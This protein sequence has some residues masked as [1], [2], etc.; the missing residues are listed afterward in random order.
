MINRANQ[1]WHPAPAPD[2]DW[3]G[4]A[5]RSRDFDD[6]YFSVDDGLAESRYVFIEGNRLHERFAGM[7]PGDALRIAETGFGTGLNF[8]LIWQLW[9][10]IAPP[11]TQLHYVGIDAYPLRL[12]ALERALEG[13]PQLQGY[14]RRLIGQWPSPLPGAHRVR[15]PDARVTLDLW[16]EDA[17]SAC[18]DLLSYGQAWIDAW[19]LDG[20][21]PARN[22]DMWSLSIFERM[23]ALSRP[24]TSFATFTAAGDVRRGLEK[25]GF[26]VQRRAGF[27]RKREALLGH[28]KPRSAATATHTLWD[29]AK[30]PP[31]RHRALVLGAGLAGAHVARALA[32]RGIEVIVLEAKDVASG[33]SSNL[34]GLTYTRFSRKFGAL[35]DFATTSYVHAT[36]HYRRLFA[37]GALE[38]GRD[39]DACGYLQLIDD[40]ETL[41]HL[42]GVAPLLGEFA[43]VLNPEQ[44]SEQLGLTVQQPAIHYPDAFW[45]NPAAVCRALL[46]HPMIHL[47]TNTGPVH[48]ARG[49]A[50]EAIAGDGR[51]LARAPLAVIAVGTQTGAVAGLEWLPLQ[52]IRGQT[53][54]LPS[55]GPLTGL[56]TALCH[57]GYLAPARDGVHC[58]GA[59]F[60]PNDAA[61]DERADDHR[62]N[63]DALAR[64]LP[65]WQQPATSAVSGHVALRCT[66]ADY[67]PVAGFVPDRAAFIERFAPLA[68]RRRQV[69]PEHAPAT[70][71]LYILSALG[72]RGLTAAPLCA[73]LIASAITAEP[74]PLPRYLHQAVA[75]A[76]FLHRGLIRGELL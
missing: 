56:R 41:V 10:S 9:D 27:G 7:Q 50:W 48:L 51:V 36:R 64:A 68:K 63:L 66:S 73:E 14:P 74:A 13:W 4:A 46:A 8:L 23:A 65:G 67:L 69:I 42:Q 55:A 22:A 3:S 37:D 21:A 1:D 30:P 52:V 75:P 5:P 28:L 60:G 76:R 33:G 45:L 38:P 58:I 29:I 39:G 62:H 34:Q 44:A 12:S 24:G 71:G 17:A 32:E 16:W 59:S 54:H 18:A 72:S 25:A 47:E 15:F 31:A 6:I 49:D 53:T 19:L 57:S 2:V 61:L 20:F 70:A 11:G 40:P 26:Q 43:Q 35:A